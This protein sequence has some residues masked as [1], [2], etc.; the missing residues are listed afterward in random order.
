[1]TES[2]DPTERPRLTLVTCYPFNF[3]GHAPQRYIVHADLIGERARREAPPGAGRRRPSGV[4]P[5]TP[6]H[7]LQLSTE[8]PSWRLNLHGERAGVVGEVVVVDA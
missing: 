2:F 1:V 5:C 3:I 4:L 6:E 7:L 8:E